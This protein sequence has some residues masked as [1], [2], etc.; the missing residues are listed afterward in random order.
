MTKKQTMQSRNPEDIQKAMTF[1]VIS[2]IAL[3]EMAATK[4][5]LAG[6]YL[7][8]FDFELERVGDNDFCEIKAGELTIVDRSKMQ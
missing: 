1:H 5:M 6:K 2:L 3:S 8:T 7:A 4:P